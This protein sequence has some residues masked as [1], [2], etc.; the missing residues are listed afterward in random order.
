MQTTYAD[1]ND[2]IVGP[3]GLTREQYVVFIKSHEDKN[4]NS[5]SLESGAFLSIGHFG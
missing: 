3:D 1:T 4:Q 5:A 2:S